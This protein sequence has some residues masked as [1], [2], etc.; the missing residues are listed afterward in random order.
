M[1]NVNK[2][3]YIPL[4][5]KAY[6]SKKGIILKDTKAEEIWEKE[7]FP[8]KGKSRSKW[9]A[10]YMGM[11]SAVF[12][13]WLI[14]KMTT[15]DNPVVIHIGCGMDS[16][17]YRT[18]SKNV[19]WYDVDF[20]DV[21]KERRRYYAESNEYHML[22]ADV[23]DP[24]WI[25][26][27][28]DNHEAIIVMEGVSMYIH[29]DKLKQMLSGVVDH[30]SNVRILM[31]CYTT[32][33]AKMSSVRNPINDV[34]GATVYGIDDPKLL[35]EDT[36]LSFVKEHEMTPQCLIDELNG[37]EK[38]FFKMV[39]AGKISRK[40]YRMYEFMGVRNKIFL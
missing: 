27:L 18:R 37:V 23:R 33:A 9:L 21:I 5:G 31:D 36:S 34:G 14:E 7:A 39:Y 30:F 12:D 4:Y 6:V 28:P 20:P 8:L 11:R 13:G 19:S 35:E 29:P 16:R 32:F 38:A 3:L 26:N 22:S 2:T 1:D 17:I 15:M 25:L 40:T 24:K 10:Y